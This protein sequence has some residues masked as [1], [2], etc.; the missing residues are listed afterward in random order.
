MARRN[1]AQTVSI[2]ILPRV[3]SPTPHPPT[4]VVFVYGTLKRGGSNHHFLA[5]QH[6]L[7]DARTA[8]G[9]RLY[10]LDGYPGMVADS[11]DTEGVTGEIWTVDPGCLA[12]LDELEGLDQGLYRREVV[13]LQPP[14]AGRA[15]QAYVYAR[16]IAGRRLLGST[17]PH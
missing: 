17:W 8:P 15:A 7:A 9:Y 4:T 14:N 16:S 13:P 3:L 10:D 12:L 11:T 6:Y 1:V 5:R 2:R